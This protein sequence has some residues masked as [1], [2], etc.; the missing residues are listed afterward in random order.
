MDQPE[1]EGLPSEIA[2]HLT[3]PFARFLKVES[4]TGVV[5]LLATAAAIILSN[6]GLSGASSRLW[7]TAV[8]LRVGSADFSR[9]LRHWVNDGL[10]TFFFFVVALELKRE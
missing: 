5:L 3:R 4:A 8:G 1:D 2:D 7:E 9:P 10:M 6:S